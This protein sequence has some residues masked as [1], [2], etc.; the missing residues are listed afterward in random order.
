[1]IQPPT[2]MNIEF[3]QRFRSS[4]SPL[5]LGPGYQTEI[6]ITANMIRENNVFVHLLVKGDYNNNPFQPSSSY[7]AH[8]SIYPKGDP[9][10]DM[11]TA[12]LQYGSPNSASQN[13][14]LSGWSGNQTLKSLEANQ[15]GGSLQGQVLAAGGFMRVYEVEG[16]IDKE[17]SIVDAFFNATRDSILKCKVVAKVLAAPTTTASQTTASALET[18]VARDGC[19]KETTSKPSDFVFIVDGSSSM[20]D[21][22]IKIAEGLQGFVSQLEAKQIS[23]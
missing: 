16:L 22:Q 17:S 7:N 20:C 15:M 4:N 9:V 19:V 23:Y 13:N 5:A 1:M 21:Y 3:Y 12:L 6:D 18:S 2:G 10:D 8:N 14:D 11:H